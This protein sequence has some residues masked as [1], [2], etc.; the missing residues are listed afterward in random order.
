MNRKIPILIIISVFTVVIGLWMYNDIQSTRSALEVMHENVLRKKSD[1]AN[2]QKSKADFKVALDAYKEELGRFKN[3]PDIVQIGVKAA[4]K[5]AKD[6]A[7]GL[8]A[9]AI[10]FYR[11]FKKESRDKQVNTV[12]SITDS[13][14]NS[15]SNYVAD[16]A[17]DHLISKLEEYVNSS[18][19]DALTEYNN[20]AQAYNSVLTTARFTVWFYDFKREPYLSE[21]GSVAELKI[22]Q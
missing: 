3:T 13:L 7:K 15:A 9:S 16:K 21:D 4:Q 2:E 11:T 14:M 22:K 19:S 10:D 1:L 8:V 5:V 18:F 6:E 20:S 12:A 17:E